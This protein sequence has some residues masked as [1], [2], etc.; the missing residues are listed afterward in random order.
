MVE[1]PQ[2]VWAATPKLSAVGEKK[3]KGTP[4]PQ[5]CVSVDFGGRGGGLKCNLAR[6]KLLFLNP[7]PPVKS[8]GSHKMQADDA[9]G[10]DAAHAQRLL[11]WGKFMKL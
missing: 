10:A 11:K 2:P 3:C 4:A 1:P 6:R 9:G 5:V 7:P 8:W